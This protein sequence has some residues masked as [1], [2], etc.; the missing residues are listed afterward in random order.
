MEGDTF[1][2]QRFAR[3][4]N[5]LFAY[6]RRGKERVTIN[7]RW[8]LRL[9]VKSITC[10]QGTEVLGSLGSDISELREDKGESYV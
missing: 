5:S 8:S 2:M 7:T 1:V 6:Q 4:S 10:A 9:G 3:L